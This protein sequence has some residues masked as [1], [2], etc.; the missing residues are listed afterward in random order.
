MDAHLKITVEEQVATFAFDWPEKRNAFNLATVREIVAGL[1]DCAQREDVR[2]VVLTGAGDAFCSGG[3]LGRLGRSAENN[4]R[5]VKDEIWD[6]IGALPKAF[7]EF[8]KPVVAA[9]NGVRQAGLTSH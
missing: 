4:P 3:D 9:V 2:A 8:D 5:A 6:D 7:V 1:R